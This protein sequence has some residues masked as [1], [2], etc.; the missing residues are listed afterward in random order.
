M[1]F[2]FS[3][4]SLAA[5]DKPVLNTVCE[6]GMFWSSI[7]YDCVACPTGTTWGNGECYYTSYDPNL[8]TT[9]STPNPNV[10][11]TNAGE[12]KMGQY[13]VTQTLITEFYST[14]DG[15]SQ[16]AFFNSFNTID[17]DYA[18]IMYMCSIL[19]TD[20][21]NTSC[22]Q[23]VANLCTVGHYNTQFCAPF[24]TKFTLQDQT[25]VG[26]YDYRY[27]PMND[28]IFIKY[29]SNVG[30]DSVMRDNIFTS[31]FYSNQEIH[32]YIAKYSPFGE[33][34][35]FEQLTDQLQF[36]HE[37]IEIVDE[38][39]KFGHNYRSACL[40]NLKAFFESYDNS[41][42]DIFLQD[43]VD[44][45]GLPILR[46]IPVIDRS[47]AGNENPRD[48]ADIIPFRRF[49]ISSNWTTNQ[50]DTTQRQYISD[51]LIYFEI[52]TQNKNNIMPPYIDIRYATANSADINST[53]TTYITNPRAD[54]SNPAY[55]FRVQYTMNADQFWNAV[56]IVFVI[57]LVLAF[58]FW[59]ICVF[60]YGRTNGEEGMTGKIIAHCASLVFDIVGTALYGIVFVLCFYMFCFFKLQKS[61]HTTLESPDA[62]YQA[63]ICVWCAF[64][65]KAIAAMISIYDQASFE[66]YLIDWEQP[67][68]ENL[69]VSTWRRIMIANEWNRILTIRSYN[70]PFTLIVMVFLLNGFDWWLMATPIPS[71]AHL[72]FG[73]Y[74]EILTI[75]LSTALF[76]VIIFIQYVW[77]YLIYWRFFGSPFLN[78]LDLCSNANISV[79]L[80]QSLNHGHYL[81]GRSLHSHSDEPMAKLNENLEYEANGLVGDRGLL[82]NTKDQV[83]EVFL[84][85]KFRAEFKNYVNQMQT[86]VPG[87]SVF[88]KAIQ[89]SSVKAAA[90]M[91]EFLKKFFDG[92]RS[93]NKF[94]V[95][96]MSFIH[97]VIRYTPTPTEDSILTIEPETSFKNLLF[98]GIEFRI[99]V[100]YIIMFVAI[101]METHSPGI[102]AFCVFI[103]DAIFIYAFNFLSKRT[104]ALKS[105][106]DRRFLL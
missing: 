87:V 1:F 43:G 15:A 88:A 38:W 73:Y 40:N 10:T 19:D 35:G 99:V 74:Y 103:T 102:A 81:H 94:Q 39:H 6:D 71:T 52:N 78:F 8:P 46:P 42:Y 100:F 58:V 50:A 33:F 20:N 77:H 12:I 66:I 95:Q 36:C 67:R 106:L 86:T 45:S 22:S 27:W 79:L 61:T 57:V 82:P 17:R 13:C 41:F 30:L 3:S 32:F 37:S 47:Y 55:Q 56:T 93:D 90:E 85:Q 83:F 26:R 54:N 24:D 60:L 92:S 84:S 80:M 23:F 11:C 25:I 53:A 63:I 48:N 65:F 97:Q 64:A 69:P 7:A 28:V 91:N 89:P 2:V 49:F 76:I 16:A 31:N 5:Q 70:L 29:P 75:A 104:L 101:E 14:G 9:G 98:S 96:P 62:Y 4:F 59:L 18:K 51:V 44:S 72:D 105:L 21:I 68:S 34:L